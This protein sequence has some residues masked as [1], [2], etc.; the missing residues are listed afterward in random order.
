M[1]EESGPVQYIVHKVSEEVSADSF[2]GR[3]Q[4]V[5]NSF[6]VS[7]ALRK[8]RD[9]MSS[10]ITASDIYKQTQIVDNPLIGQLPSRTEMAAELDDLLMCM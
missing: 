9:Q 2:S 10:N 5:D 8:L 7:L 4:K 3:L 1:T 6:G